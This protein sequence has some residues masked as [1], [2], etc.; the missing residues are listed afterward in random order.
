M[1]F[2][3]YFILFKLLLIILYICNLNY[4]PIIPIESLSLAPWFLKMFCSPLCASQWWTSQLL[5]PPSIDLWHSLLCNQDHD[6]NQNY[7][8]VFVNLMCQLTFYFLREFYMI[9]WILYKAKVIWTRPSDPRYFQVKS[10]WGI[11]KMFIINY[12]VIQ[13]ESEIHHLI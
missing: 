9:N 8:Q 6:N 13:K 1:L 2:S 4:F 7:K 3:N 11:Q 5:P 12:S 10:D